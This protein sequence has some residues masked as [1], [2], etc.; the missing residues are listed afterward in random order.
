MR[1]AKWMALI[2]ALAIVLLSLGGSPATGAKGQILKRAAMG[3]LRASYI[4][5]KVRRH[6]RVVR[7]KRRMPA[8]AAG[9]IAAARDAMGLGFASKRFQKFF[10]PPDTGREDHTIPADG[11]GGDGS[12]S[13]KSGMGFRLA[14]YGCSGRLGNSGG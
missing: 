12:G 4:S 11:G 5:V 2:A 3:Q 6:G 13:G 14:T 10:V 9:T 7:V 1:Y 8:I